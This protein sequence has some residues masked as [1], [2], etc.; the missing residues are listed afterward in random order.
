MALGELKSGNNIPTDT[1]LNKPDMPADSKAVG[2]KIDELKNADANI[3]SSIKFFTGMNVSNYSKDCNAVPKP[4]ILSC[5][6]MSSISNGP[7]SEAGR[8]GL[9][10]TL[11]ANVQSTQTEHT[12]DTCQFWLDYY[13]N[14]IYYRRAGNG[15]YGAWVKLHG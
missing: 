7:T 11:S 10:V 3:L 9:L 8:Y 14:T 6:P 5:W 1:E 15:A 2:D 12:L 4:S 13:S